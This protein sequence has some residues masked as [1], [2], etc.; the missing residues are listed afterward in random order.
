[1]NYS[2]VSRESRLINA[3]IVFE[4]LLVHKEAEYQYHRMSY[5]IEDIIDIMRH[6]NTE[7]LEEDHSKMGRSLFDINLKDLMRFEVDKTTKPARY[8][9]INEFRPQ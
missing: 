3:D 4:M 5:Y 1:M 9:V 7:V 6:L 8:R 2:Q